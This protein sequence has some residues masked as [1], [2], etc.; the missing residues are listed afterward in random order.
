LSNEFFE[1]GVSTKAESRRARK[2][3]RKNKQLART[4]KPV[5]A[6]SEKQQHYLDAMD[7]ST[8]VFGIGPAGVGKTYLAAR[9]AARKLKDG[10]ISRVYIARAT[11]TTRRHEIGHLPGGQDSK[12]KPWMVPLVEAMVEEIGKT[13][14]DRRLNDKTI[15]V[16]PFAFMRGRTFKDAIVIVDEAQNLSLADFKLLLTRQG[17]ECQYLINGDPYQS[18]IPDSGLMTVVHMVERFDLDAE[19]VTFSSADVE[20][21]H[22]ARQWVMAFEKTEDGIHV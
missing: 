22:H 21:S 6:R 1:D 15:E 7:T 18:D 12:M 9:R 14:V 13:E 19:I 16:V 2:E 5:T 3:A 8:Q 4:P 20:R 11:V 10:D 17:E